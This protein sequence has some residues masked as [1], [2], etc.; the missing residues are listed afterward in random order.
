[1]ARVL[2][3]LKS[4]TL[5]ELTIERITLLAEKLKEDNTGI[6]ELAIEKLAK[7]NKIK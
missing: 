5:S 4:Y 1:M 2:K 6:V 3:K 7:A